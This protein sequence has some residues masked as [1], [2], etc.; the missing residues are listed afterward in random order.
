MKRIWLKK[1]EN[2]IKLFGILIRSPRDYKR[3][4]RYLR[5]WQES[6][7]P[8]WIAQPEDFYFVSRDGDKPAGQARGHYF[9][10]D[11]WAAQR[12]YALNPKLHVD[13]GSRVDGFVSHVASF[14]PVE[15]VDIRKLECAVPNLRSKVGMIHDLPYPSHSLVSLSCLHVIE[16]I[17]LGRYGDPINPDGWIAGLKELQRVLA[18]NGQLLLSTPCG[19]QRV[20]FNAHR[21]F[22]ATRIV[23]KL[24]ELD[25]IEF[26]FIPNN[27]ATAWI[28]NHSLAIDGKIDYGCG[29][30]RLTRKSK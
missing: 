26:S 8:E 30:F 15:Y 7:S 25:L 14:A 18:P 12:V 5:L 29:L 21:I 6:A 17:G 22:H 13:V 11:L 24:D 23:E 10:Q 3:Q 1:I 4:M 9:L 20:E 16:H 27:K 28:E 19:R 2:Y